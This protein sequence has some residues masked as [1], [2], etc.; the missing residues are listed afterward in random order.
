MK[1]FLV[2]IYCVLAV[3]SIVVRRTHQRAVRWSVAATYT[4]RHAHARG[5]WAQSL[6]VVDYILHNA[7]LFGSSR[8]SAA[9]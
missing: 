6:S 5:P 2:F 9:R 3:Q 1:Q 7:I 4:P 8:V